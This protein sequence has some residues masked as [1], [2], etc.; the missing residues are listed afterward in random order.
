MM[1]LDYFGGFGWIS[2]N[3]NKNIKFGQF[4]GPT[5]WRRDPM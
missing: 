5:S 3:R 1:L 2:G 4:Q